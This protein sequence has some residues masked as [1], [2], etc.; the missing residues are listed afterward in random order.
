MHL[1]GA[2][3]QPQRALAAYSRA[4]GVQFE[5]P[6][7][8]CIWIASSMMAQTRSG[9][10]AFTALTHTRASALPIV[11]IAFAARSTI[12]RIASISMRAR[13]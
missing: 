1:V 6:V 2:V 10:S 13:R 11:S 7:A 9:T 5:T 3:G 4:S 8:P 12:S